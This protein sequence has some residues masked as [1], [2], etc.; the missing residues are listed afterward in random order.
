MASKKHKSTSSKKSKNKNKKNSGNA[1]P[2]ASF[3]QTYAVQAMMLKL[4]RHFQ[5]GWRD[6]NPNKRYSNAP[7]LAKLIGRSRS[8]FYRLL[9][10]LQTDHHLPI[11]IVPEYGGYGYTEEVVSFP[12]VQFSQAELIA[13]FAALN[14]LKSIRGNP[15][16][17][18]AESAF[19]K[20][21]LALDEELTVDLAA[22]Q[23]VVCFRSGGFPAPVDPALI[24][25]AVRACI[26]HEELI[27]HHRKLPKNGEKA[28]TKEYRVKPYFV[29]CAGE[30]WYLYTWNYEAGKVRRFALART[31]RIER[32]GVHFKL[33]K[34]YNREALIGTGFG[35]GLFGDDKP[36]PARVR[37]NAELA[38]LIRERIWHPSQK[39]TSEGED[40]GIVLHLHVSHDFELINWI[41]GWGRSATVLEPDTLKGA[42]EK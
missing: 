28:K 7:Q 42:V 33:P 22:L 21:A 35:Y 36:Q 29:F 10:H 32:T 1:D 8:G 27:L 13:I 12:A 2:V 30:V 38:P 39:I 3:M 4:H 40:G 18:A 41:R 5:Q 31:K 34:D 26:D 19:Q 25:T 9:N 16:N 20:L 37:F 14:S 6:K 23:S 24:E 17:D 15:F 11:D